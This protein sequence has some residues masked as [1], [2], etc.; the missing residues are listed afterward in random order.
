MFGIILRSMIFVTVL[1]PFSAT[2]EP[3][4]LK[5]SFF[6]SDRSVANLSTVQPFVD[7]VNTEAKGRLE[8]HVY[9]TGALGKD[10]SNTAQ[11]VLDGTAD[12][13]FVVL[14]LQPPGL[15]PDD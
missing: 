1:V 14:G 9:F 12:I 7:A 15:F 2:A 4:G 6:T 8:I 5:L 10:Q 11:S 3:V 13:A